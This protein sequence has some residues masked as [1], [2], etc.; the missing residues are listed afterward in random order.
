VTLF[1]SVHPKSKK[2]LRGLFLSPKYFA[3]KVHKSQQQKQRKNREKE[4]KNREKLRKFSSFARK[5]KI[6]C[7]VRT[8]RTLAF[9]MYDVHLYILLFI[10]NNLNTSLM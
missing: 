9:G 3:K 2:S 7:R 5:I 6:I 1:A 8:P 4:K 10:S